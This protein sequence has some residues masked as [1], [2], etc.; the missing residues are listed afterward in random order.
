MH[1]IAAL[2]FTSD[3]LEII[4]KTVNNFFNRKELPFVFKHY[5]TLHEISPDEIHKLHLMLISLSD[6]PKGFFAANILRS[7]YSSKELVLIFVGDVTDDIITAIHYSPLRFVRKKQ[8][9]SDMEEALT[10]Y[11]ARNS[12]VSYVQFSDHGIFRQIPAETIMYLS[13]DGHYVTLH[14]QNRRIK[15]RAKLSNYIEVLK[16]EDF[17]QIHK[18]YIVNMKYIHKIVKNNVILN[19]NELLP[20][21]RT[22]KTIF[23]EVYSHFPEPLKQI[24]Q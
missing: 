22:Y 12:D 10:A 17:V 20:V 13:S 6:S 7:N 14:C 4:S 24:I 9:A 1:R 15:L 3:S 5:K 23:I 19:N 21:S 8:L 11:I 18:S 16:K 2:N